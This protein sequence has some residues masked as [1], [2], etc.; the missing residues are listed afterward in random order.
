MGDDLPHN[1]PPADL[2]D[3][4]I[5]VGHETFDFQFAVRRKGRDFELRRNQCQRLASLVRIGLGQ[6]QVLLVCQGDEGVVFKH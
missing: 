2:V 6:L 3:L 1:D 4:A 5:R